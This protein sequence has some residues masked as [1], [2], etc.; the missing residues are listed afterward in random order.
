MDSSRNRVEIV[1]GLLINTPHRGTTP[2]DFR[3]DCSI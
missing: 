2:P 1:H 3:N